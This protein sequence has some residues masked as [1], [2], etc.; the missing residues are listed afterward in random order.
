MSD[1][2]DRIASIMQEFG[3]SEANTLRAYCDLMC[4]ETESP[5]ER[6]FAYALVGQSIVMGGNGRRLLGAMNR[7]LPFDEIVAEVSRAEPGLIGT[8]AQVGFNNYRLDFIVSLRGA[9]GTWFIAVEC[10]GHEF[11]E[12]TADQAGRDKARDRDL[13]A[14]GIMVFRFTG[15]E[16][17]RDAWACAGSVI[18][19]LFQRDIDEFS[20][21]QGGE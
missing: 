19:A 17:W 7:R 13:Q 9:V 10:D 12:R 11:H 2:N 1:I 15:R 5:I 4:T 14:K 16:I 20:K 21:D 18:D 8:W 6:L 3:N